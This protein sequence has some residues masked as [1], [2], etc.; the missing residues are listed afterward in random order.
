[1]TPEERF[2]KILQDSKYIRVP[3]EDPAQKFQ[4][5]QEA[6]KDCTWYNPTDEDEKQMFE[7]NVKNYFKQYLK[8][9]ILFAKT[10]KPTFYDN[11][12]L[13]EDLHTMDN[14]GFEG[15]VMSVNP[16]VFYRWVEDLKEYKTIIPCEHCKTLY[17]EGVLKPNQIRE[18]TINNVF[19]L[20]K[21]HEEERKELD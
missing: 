9:M 19:P 6:C 15:Q 2:Y 4:A 8:E 7:T 21:Q 14:Q 17:H 20:C 12:R 16:L 11:E 1:M 18:A 5:F 10:Q 13:I 3:D